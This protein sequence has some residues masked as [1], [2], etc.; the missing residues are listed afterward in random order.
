MRNYLG[1]HNHTEF[2]NIKVIDSINRA[3]RMIDYA[4]DLNMSGL[5]FTDH[6]CV[7]GALKFLKAYK[8]KLEKEWTKVNPDKELPTYEQMSQDLDFKVI[9]GNEIY[10]S[11][12]GLTEANMNGVDPCHFWHYILIAKDEIGFK[13]IKQ[14]SSAAWR[15]AW[16]RNMLRTP[17]YP[18]DLFKFIEGGHVV[19]S[20]A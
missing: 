15:R 17:T 8:K 11:E 18:S 20:T 5:V 2:S 7:S 12:E 19:A 4:W 6:D 14:L 16:F 10:L 13:Q 9:L 3:D 1:I